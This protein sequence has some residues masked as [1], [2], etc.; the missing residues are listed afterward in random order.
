MDIICGGAGSDA[1]AL[2]GERAYGKGTLLAAIGKR[3][4]QT[5]HNGAKPALSSACIS[6]GF[7]AIPL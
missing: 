5:W 7:D 6:Q 4:A 2:K 1:A 3:P